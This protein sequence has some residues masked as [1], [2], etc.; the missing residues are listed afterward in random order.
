MP[1]IIFKLIFYA[2]FGYCFLSVAWLTLL[3][4]SGKY[5]YKSRKYTNAG[6][7]PSKKIAIIVPA[8]KE[9]NVILSTAEHL[10]AL[11]Y[12]RELYD[13]H[14]MAD[15]FQ[16]QTLQALA[17]LPI[18]VHEVNFVNRTV[19][20]ALNH[21]FKVI[22]KPY[23]VAMIS[24]GDN[25][26]CN[27]FLQIVNE[28]FTNGA[29]AMQGR[30]VAKNLDSSFAILDACSEGI[31]NHIFRKGPNGL[32]LSSA[33][34]GSGMAFDFP[35]LGRLLNSIE[36]VG[37]DKVLQLK[38]MEEGNFIYFVHDAI[39]YD[40]K[41]DSSQAFHNQRKRW[42][43][44][45]FEYLREYFFPA[46]RQ[47]FKGNVSYFNLVLSN[48]LILPKGY[49]FV[50]L[51]ALVAVSFFVS[52][53]WGLAAAGL[54]LVFMISIAMAVPKSL[55][56]RQLWTAILSLPKA[57]FLMVRVLFQMKKTDNKVFIHTTHSKTTV[58]NLG[59]TNTSK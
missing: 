25:V 7:P 59:E 32:G 49:L 9:D 30:R 18:Y 19:T 45:Q 46:F 29:V 40:E 27:D 31:N 28:V 37:F 3:S 43:S 42:I 26:P 38:I 23:D 15:S 22:G 13:I 17:K 56:N 35:M 11:N 5:F 48:Y 52:L 41:V 50:V 53:P 55:V 24:D 6:L 54:L 39:Q 33:V 2:F 47:L 58:S 10:L 14:I 51:P 57:I 34:A 36:A 4:L 1:Y 20:K 21:A 44:T 12:P 8:Y 16:P